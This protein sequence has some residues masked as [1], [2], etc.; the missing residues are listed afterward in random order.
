MTTPYEN[1]MPI[2]SIRYF[3]DKE[4]KDATMDWFDFCLIHDERLQ[5]YVAADDEDVVENRLQELADDE[6]YL[7]GY[8]E[9]RQEDLVDSIAE[10]DNDLKYNLC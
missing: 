5:Q 8:A 3:S 10:Y 1:E 4:A 7:R 9:Y 2:E 6:D